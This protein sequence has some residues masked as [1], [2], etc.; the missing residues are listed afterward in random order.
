MAGRYAEKRSSFS[1]PTVSTALKQLTEQKLVTESGSVYSTG[2]RKA[3]GYAPVLDAKFSLG[4]DASEQGLRIVL[5]DLS[6]SNVSE[7]PQIKF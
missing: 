5:L 3:V 4:A 2:G 1:L 6:G 7:A